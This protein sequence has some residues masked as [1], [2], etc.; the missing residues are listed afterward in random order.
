MKLTRL[1]LAL[2]A[3]C[4]AAP[5]AAQSSPGFPL[6]GTV[7]SSAGTLNSTPPSASCSTTSGTTA[8]G[9]FAPTLGSPQRDAPPVRIVLKGGAS[10]TGYLA[11][12]VTGDCSSYNQLTAGGT[13]ISFSGSADEF[14]DVPPGTGGV[15]YCIV[16]TVAS[17]TETFA[18][19]Q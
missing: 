2:V 8:C 11:T 18:V 1:A 3:L 19:R 14:V 17:G 15:Q 16:L 5:L 6:A 7:T 13:P 9:P 4:A 12:T 10:F